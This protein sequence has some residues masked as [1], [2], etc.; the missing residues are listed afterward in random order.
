MLLSI[1]R[2][3]QLI[4]EG[5]NIEKIAEL[6]ECDISEVVDIIQEAREL[7]LKHEKAFAK[8]KIILKKRLSQEMKRALMNRI[9]NK[10][11]MNRI[12]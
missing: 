12:I 10:I 3:L 2:I 5:K 7:L 1:D 9:M 11:L 8:R 6:A 4:S